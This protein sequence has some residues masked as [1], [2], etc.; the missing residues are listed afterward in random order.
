MSD[1]RGMDMPIVSKRALASKISRLS[2][3]QQRE[4][5]IMIKRFGVSFSS[6]KNGH[7]FD[8]EDV[9]R[10]CLNM[11]NR[12]VDYSI[13]NQD[14]LDEYDRSIQDIGKSSAG[15]FSSV[16]HESGE[17]QKDDGNVTTDTTSDTREES[18]Q[19]PT[20]EPYET[21]DSGTIGIAHICGADTATVVSG[22]DDGNSPLT[23]FTP[24]VPI[25]F[26]N[27]KKR[28]CKPP[29]SKKYDPDDVS[30]LISL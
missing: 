21:S 22:A 12:F 24:P 2:C 8:L 6:N 20:H 1:K 19:Q 18:H 23:S 3:I 16:H 27:C 30:S 29:R 7:F 14:Q 28:F 9:P 11:I 26:L 5:L 17:E 13:A 25:K 15:A 10:E 4:I